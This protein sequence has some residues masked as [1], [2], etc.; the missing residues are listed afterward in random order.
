MNIVEQTNTDPWNGGMHRNTLAAQK[1]FDSAETFCD[2]QVEWS[3]EYHN[4]VASADDRARVE[5]LSG[6]KDQI[7]AWYWDDSY[8]AK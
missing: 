5:C 2:E 3:R 4:N 8:R 1:A 7:V 6:D